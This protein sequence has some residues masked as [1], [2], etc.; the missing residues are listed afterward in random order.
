M[1]KWRNSYSPF[2]LFHFCIGSLAMG[3][4]SFLHLSVVFQHDIF[5]TFD[6]RNDRGNAGIGLLLFLAVIGL[7][8]ATVVMYRTVQKYVKRFGID[9]MEEMVLDIPDTDS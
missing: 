8:R 2:S 5:F 3:L 4:I 7:F 9:K 6:R 1:Q